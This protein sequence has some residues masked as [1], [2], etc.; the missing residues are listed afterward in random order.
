MI[1][2]NYKDVTLR[3]H[4]NS[5]YDTND[6][7]DIVLYALTS[8]TDGGLVPHDVHFHGYRPKMNNTAYWS[9]IH[10]NNQTLPIP[11]IKRTPSKRSDFWLAD[12]DCYMDTAAQVLL[13]AGNFQVL[14]EEA[15]S[16]AL[17]GELVNRWV[18]TMLIHV[19]KPN[20]PR[21]RVR[22][23]EEIE[24]VS[25][26]SAKDAARLRLKRIAVLDKLHA[27]KNHAGVLNSVLQ[28][29]VAQRA[30]LLKLKDGAVDGLSE[31]L[32][33]KPDFFATNA[34]DF[35]DALQACAD[36]LDQLSDQHAALHYYLD[37]SA[38]GVRE[39]EM[40][41]VECLSDSK[42]NPFSEE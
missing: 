24:V 5:K 12:P 32:R 4:N 6:L 27:L 13:A 25:K 30:Q 2:I 3:L 10:R 21:L 31:A 18:S 19:D 34:Y 11:F 16:Q 42:R 9:K 14:T 36:L 7:A 15:Y 40:N 37:S 17:L 23:A 28:S 1:S 35:T 33:L 8:I 20:P 29:V 22:L 26:K 39:A 41:V 38:V